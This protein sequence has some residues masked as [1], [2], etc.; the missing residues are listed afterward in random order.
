MQ[1]VGPGKRKQAAAYLLL[2]GATLLDPFMIL[3]LLVGCQ[4]VS[5]FS[6]M[7]F[8]HSDGLLYPKLTT[9]ESANHRWNLGS[10]NKCFF[11]LSHFPVVFFNHVDKNLACILHKAIMAIRC[12]LSIVCVK[13]KYTKNKSTKDE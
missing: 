4:K 8:C 12:Y 9:V 1:K 11:I 3:P 6:S 13:F 10:H 5:K 2:K 7:C